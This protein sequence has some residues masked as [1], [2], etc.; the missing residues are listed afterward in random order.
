MSKRFGTVAATWRIE[1]LRR[2]LPIS[3]GASYKREDLVPHWQSYLSSLYIMRLD[4][5]AGS[6]PPNPEFFYSK[7]VPTNIK[8]Q[9]PDFRVAKQSISQGQEF[10]KHGHGESGQDHRSIR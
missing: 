4:L 5:R 8:Y 2:S 7:Q 10:W 1:E 6:I 9:R 3:P